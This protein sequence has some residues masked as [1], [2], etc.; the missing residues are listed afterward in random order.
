MNKLFYLLLIFL[1]I[2]SCIIFNLFIYYLITD[3]IKNK[4][5]H[6]IFN[7]LIFI[8][9]FMNIS[10]LISIKYLYNNLILLI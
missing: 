1:L 5:I 3:N 9:I 2:S 4:S 7:F 10:C 8:F 6:L